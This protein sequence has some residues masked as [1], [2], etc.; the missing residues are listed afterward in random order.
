MKRI[1]TEGRNLIRE[2]EDFVGH[3]YADPA[4]P[5]GKALQKAGQWRRHLNTPG[6]VPEGL[7]SLSG[8]PWTIGYGFTTVNGRKVQ[9]HDRMTQ[10]EAEVILDAELVEYEEAVEEA[11]TV[12]P[13]ENEFSA[14]VCLAWNI[15][16]KAFKGSS[17]LKAHNR[18]DRQA[19]ARAY[20]L[21]NKAG[22]KVM[23]GLTRRRAAESALHLKPAPLMGNIPPNPEPITQNV[24]GE[25]TLLKSPIIG[26]SA[27]TA[28][29]STLGL[30]AEGAR[31]ARDIKESLGEALPW[32]LVAILLASVFVMYWRNKQRKQGWS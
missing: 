23:D 31:S 5:L 11:C 1:N 2:F 24:Q 20:G 7:Q 28:G 27:V 14:M 26:G 15:G 4:S 29:A 8:A 25:T 16:I 13:N 22:G 9:P 12:E 18:G 10:L 3:A 19:A 30:V 17:I 21:W 6:Y 32:I